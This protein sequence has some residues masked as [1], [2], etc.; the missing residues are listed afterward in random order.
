MSKQSKAKAAQGYVD[1]AIPST[2]ATCAKFRFDLVDANAA[3]NAKYET[4]YPPYFVS[5]N[6]RCEIGGFA[7]KKLGTCNEWAKAT[8]DAA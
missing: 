8:G 4:K 1:K 2:C 6:M 3:H 5:K 7:V